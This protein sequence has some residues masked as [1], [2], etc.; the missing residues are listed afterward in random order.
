MGS[1]GDV[2]IHNIIGE[3]S[4]SVEGTRNVIRCV[5]HVFY[6]IVGTLVIWHI[7]IVGFICIYVADII[8]VVVVNKNIVVLWG[9]GRRGTARRTIWRLVRVIP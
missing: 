4:V 2:T 1:V 9:D 5:V 8:V 3:V 7:D 6:D